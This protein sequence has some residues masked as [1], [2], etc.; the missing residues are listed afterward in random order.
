MP[1]LAAIILA[2]FKAFPALENLVNA[3]LAERARQREAEALQRKQQKDTAVSD[4]IAAG[5]DTP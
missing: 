4:W 3:A 2:I 1:T 5:K